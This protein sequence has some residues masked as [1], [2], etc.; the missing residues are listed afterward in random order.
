MDG[1]RH[2]PTTSERS[3]QL[4]MVEEWPEPTEEPEEEPSHEKVPDEPQ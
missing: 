2:Y 3:F 1:R 4:K